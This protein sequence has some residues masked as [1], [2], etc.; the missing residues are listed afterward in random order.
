MI[1]MWPCVCVSWSVQ[2]LFVGLYQHLK[3]I[4]LINCQVFHFVHSLSQ[5]VCL[6]FSAQQEVYIDVSHLGDRLGQGGGEG[7]AESATPP[8]PSPLCGWGAPGPP[9]CWASWAWRSRR[10][11]RRIV[12]SFSRTIRRKV[13]T[14]ELALAYTSCTGN[15]CIKDTVQCVNAQA[16]GVLKRQYSV[17]GV[18]LKKQS[19]ILGNLTDQV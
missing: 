11:W 10:L 8:S 4:C 1:F 2:Y 16:T 7:E 15:R 3:G 19:N 18:E 9:T 12:W 14:W 6:L 17:T 5:T 13:C